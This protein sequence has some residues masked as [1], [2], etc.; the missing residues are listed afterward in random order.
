MPSINRVIP[1]T[2]TTL[3][4]THIGTGTKLAK[5]FD[6]YVD[7]QTTYII[8]SDVALEYALQH[9]EER[10]PPEA[11]QQK[12]QE[13]LAQKEAQLKRRREHNLR[14]IEEFERSKPR[15]PA[16]R[17][18]R[19]QGLE[20]DAEEY[21]ALNTD[22]RRLRANPPTEE[23]IRLPDELIANSQ[24]DHL[25]LG[26]WLPLSSIREQATFNGRRI[27]RYSLAGIPK[28]ELYEQ[29]KD[30]H[31][32]I[33]IPG[34]S[35]K[36]ALRSALAWDLFSLVPD[37]T[38]AQIPNQRKKTADDQ[39]DAFLF[40]GRGDANSTV[41]DVLRTLHISDCLAASNEMAA[42]DTQIYGAKANIPVTIEAIA[43]NVAFNGTM[44]IERYAFENPQARQRIDFSN[45]QER[46]QPTALAATCRRRA[47]ALI[48]G[49]RIFYSALA[50][51]NELL[52]F[53]DSLQQHLEQ[54]PKQ[55][56]LLPIGWGTGW[57]SKTV[58]NRLR[59]TPGREVLF[60]SI[61]REY[62]LK[63]K[64]SSSFRPNGTFPVTRKVILQ[65]QRP[66][67]PLGWVQVDF[68]KER[69]R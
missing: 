5:N 17:K 56:C 35:L 48:E 41:R 9:W 51:A 20:K 63:A 13:E 27:V 34:S 58:D 36:G 21:Q 47:S 1:I 19:E 10:Y 55:S 52:R 60:Q 3:T 6:Y 22:V 31:D 66:W 46:L 54:L 59:G 39:I 15:D 28:N 37:G 43:A 2:I 7:G 49:E 12:Y 68:G 24:L 33:Y 4:P 32:Q 8:D 38:I 16:E 26:D 67:R 11:A 69:T 50:E 40:L 23:D 61:V 30:I 42:C 14:K 45:W 53:Y 65:N 29:I 18:K 57:R 25:I 64:G 44:Q 62:N